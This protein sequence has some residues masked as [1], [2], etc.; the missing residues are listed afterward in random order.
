MEYYENENGEIAVLYSP[1]YGTGWS[2][3]N[4]HVE[5]AYDKHV[6]ELFMKYQDYEITVEEIEND[7]KEYFNTKY[8]CMGGWTHLKIEWIPH[9]IPFRIR[10]YDGH[11]YIEY[12]NRAGF[13]TL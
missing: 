2:T 9:G 7:L 10:E 13:T 12:L 8:I 1:G 4:S 5:I 3:C 11:E 6:V